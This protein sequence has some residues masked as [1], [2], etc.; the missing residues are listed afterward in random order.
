[1]ERI[2]NMPSPEKKHRVKKRGVEETTASSP[3]SILNE[4]MA[5]VVKAGQTSQPKSPSRRP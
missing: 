3:L 4:R 1:M 5:Y 2:F